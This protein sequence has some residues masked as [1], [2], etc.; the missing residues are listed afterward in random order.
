MNFSA[1]DTIEKYVIES[2]LGEGGMAVVY[3][4]RH[5]TLQTQYALKILKLRMNI[6]EIE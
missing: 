3:K 4:V 1:G 2:V 5:Q 6:S